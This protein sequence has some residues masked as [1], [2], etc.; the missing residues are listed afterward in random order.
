M[1]SWHLAHISALEGYSV[2][3]CKSD[4]ERKQISAVLSDSQ[5]KLKP[6][7]SS[8][9]A[10]SNL[11]LLAHLLLHA[12]ITEMSSPAQVRGVSSAEK[13]RPDKAKWGLQLGS[14]A[15]ERQGKRYTCMQQNSVYPQ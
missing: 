2:S 6:R 15:F 1:N 10:S 8:T 11:C 5:L 7:T 3:Y 9:E 14:C 4:W 12:G 13:H